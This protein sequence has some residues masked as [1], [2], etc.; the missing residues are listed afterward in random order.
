[1]ACCKACCGCADCSE[2]QQ[3]KCCC[4]GASGS[5]CSASEYC[6]SGACQ[7]T[8]C[9]EEECVTDEDCCFDEGWSPV[10]PC[11]GSG[12][13]KCCPEGSV[14]WVDDIGD[15]RAGNC[16]DDCDPSGGV[17][18]SPGT[19]GFCCDNVCQAGEC[20][21]CCCCDDGVDVTC[22]SFD[23]SGVPQYET[24]CVTGVSAP[25]FGNTFG[26]CT[27]TGTF[28]YTYGECEAPPP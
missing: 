25:V 12:E 3:G 14:G 13:T 9:E 2:G 6:C 18:A 17:V 8:P 11:S 4:G 24:D 21:I 23:I 26:D 10:P 1:M 5:C 27:A 22:Y 15:A 20:Y 28:G 7:G 19:K 16:V